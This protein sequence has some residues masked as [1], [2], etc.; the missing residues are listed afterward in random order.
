M[1]NEAQ[2]FLHHKGEID[3]MIAVLHA[4]RATLT[5][6]MIVLDLGAGQGMHAGFLSLIAGRVYCADLLN[7]STLY[8]GQFPKLL[9]EKHQ[10]NGYPFA[11]SKIEFNQTDAMDMVYRDSLFDLVVSI[12]SFEH[13]PDP[14]KALCEMARVTKDGGYIYVSADPIWTADTGSHFFHRVPEPWA[15][16]VYSD[17]QFC[18][19][20]SANGAT[21]GEIAEYDVAMNRLRAAD[22]SN[23]IREV[24]ASGGVITVFSESW[25]GV[26]DE[27]HRQHANVARLKTLGFSEQELLIRGMRWLFRKH[28]TP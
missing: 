19:Q 12:N 1:Y 3:A 22:Y 18:Q 7:Y 17:D 8:E 13:I 9:N 11:L 21:P 26:Q 4:Q 28:L 24:T 5:P 6:E 2:D 14:K 25:S 27:S 20:M 15:H 23:I 10:R 16:L